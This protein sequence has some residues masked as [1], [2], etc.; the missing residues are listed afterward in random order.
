[1]GVEST[2]GGIVRTIIT[3]TGMHVPPHVVDNHRLARIMD[4]SDEWIR[5]RTGIVTRHFAGA[6]EGTSD[7]A[8]PAAERALADAGLA[9][10]SIDY[11]VF[12]TMTPDFYFPGS[13]AILQRKLGLPPVPCLDIRQ[14]CAGFIYGMQIAD[15]LVRAGGPRHVLVI[16]AEVHS[17]LMPWRCWDVVLGES[18]RAIPPEDGTAGVLDAEL[19]TAGEHADKMWVP[20][21]G[22]AYRPYFDPEMAAR[23]DTIPIVEGREVFR[24]AVTLMPLAVLEILA[25][26]ALTLDDLDLLVVH[27]ANLRIAEAIQKRLGIPDEKVFNNIQK[28]GNTTAATIPIAF[29]EAR[30]AGRVRPGALVCF[31]GLGSGL[32]WGA[33]L[34]RCPEQRH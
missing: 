25:R 5:Q 20:A 10:E 9:K 12:A 32:H 7:L 11:V 8:V 33:V 23:G 17:G 26:N 31:V 3:G 19:H 16:G 30:R 28:Y 27:Q 34:Y 21:G 22:S 6:G 13:G 18:D 2:G 14:Q 4:T 24:T 15:A 1:V 29:H